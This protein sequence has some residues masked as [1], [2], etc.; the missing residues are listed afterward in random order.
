MFKRILIPTD[1][2]SVA[3][4]AIKAGIALANGFG[5][6]IVAYHAREPIE[7]RYYAQGTGIRASEIRAIDKRLGELGE[8]YL[9]EICKGATAAGVRCETVMTSPAAPYLGIIAAARKKKCDV[10]FMA[11]HGRG[12]LASLLIG[13]VTQKVL[14]HST[15]PVLVYR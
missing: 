7:Y 9:A 3:R 4:K 15:I 6:T 13:S 12:K 14:T 10:I 1:G 5:A 8:R 2:S 11:S